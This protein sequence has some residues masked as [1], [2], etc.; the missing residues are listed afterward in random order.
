M[1][2]WQDKKWEGHKMIGGGVKEKGEK[3][4][5]LERLKVSKGEGED[6]IYEWNEVRWSAKVKIKLK[7]MKQNNYIHT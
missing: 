5:G 2:D 6:R 3:V 4:R 7:R 1:G